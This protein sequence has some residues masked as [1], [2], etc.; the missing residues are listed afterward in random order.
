[1]VFSGFP[2][3]STV[4]VKQSQITIAFWLSVTLI[5]PT[6]SIFFIQN[7][8]IL[9]VKPLFLYFILFYFVAAAR[10]QT[11]IQIRAVG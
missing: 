1:V 8:S 6:E 2:N 7:S 9:F 5:H 11:F 3:K 4:L 10:R